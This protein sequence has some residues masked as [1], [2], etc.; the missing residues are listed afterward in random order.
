MSLGVIEA[1]FNT[2]GDAGLAGSTIKDKKTNANTK[3]MI[4]AVSDFFIK[5][6]FA[7]EF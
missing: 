5:T 2:I 1:H 6:S 7:R 4:P 3:Q